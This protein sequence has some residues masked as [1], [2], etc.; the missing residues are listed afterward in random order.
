M[1]GVT[2]RR[3]MPAEGPFFAALTFPAY[4]SWLSSGEPALLAIAVQVDNEPAGLALAVRE[5]AGE[6]AELCSIFVRQAYR[7]R[8]LSAGLLERLEAALRE[9]GAHEVHGVYMTGKPSTPVLEHLLATRGWDA[10]ER[11][12]LVLRAHYDRMSRAPW[13]AKASLGDGLTLDRWDAL[14]SCER[15]ELRRSQEASPWIAPDLIPFDFEENSYA[16]ASLVLRRGGKV[17][18]WLITHRF[19]DVLRYTCSYVHPELQRRARIL[20]LYAEVMRRA[21]AQGISQGIWT[22]PVQHP[23]MMAFA[24]RWM[25]PYAEACDETRGTRKRLRG[26]SS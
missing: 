25:A 7:R 15:A 18:G 4:R 6:Q 22:I 11:R 20:P 21:H 13:V 12:M 26:L 9:E 5:P 1:A 17:V 23:A 3:L 10:P 19:G 8:G 16:P 24:Q 2:Y 14:T